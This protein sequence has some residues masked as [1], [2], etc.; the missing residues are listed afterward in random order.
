M[1]YVFKTNINTAEEA[2]KASVFINKIVNNSSW[3]FDLEDCDRILRIVI[4]DD[5]DVSHLEQAFFDNGFY[6]CELE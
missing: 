2:K 3:N 4:A 5:L 6:C 1:V